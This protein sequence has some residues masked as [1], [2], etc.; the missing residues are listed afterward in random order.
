M[1]LRNNVRAL[2]RI[3]N[4]TQAD[5]AVL[6]S[7]GRSTIS[8][9]ERGEHIPGVDVALMIAYALGVDVEEA[10]WLQRDSGGTEDG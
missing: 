8:D 6:A 3:R 2:R 7:V 4:I 5:L 9:I 10:F 1:E